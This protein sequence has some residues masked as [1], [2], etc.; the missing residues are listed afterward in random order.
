M[1]ALWI[2]FGA[3]LTCSDAIRQNVVES[4]AGKA[5]V[6]GLGDDCTC[7]KQEENTCCGPGLTCTWV[8]GKCK[9]ALKAECDSKWFGTDCGD[10]TYDSRGDGIGCHKY[11]ADGQKRCCVQSLDEDSEAKTWY[12]FR[13]VGDKTSCCSGETTV[14]GGYTYC[15]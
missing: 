7:G 15:K 5:T 14:K 10:S 3:C 8:S 9:L 2:A 4:V 11:Y 12:R 1:R 6:L 13:P